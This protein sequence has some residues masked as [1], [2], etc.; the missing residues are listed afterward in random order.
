M[1]ILTKTFDGPSTDVQSGLVWGEIQPMGQMPSRLPVATSVL[2]QAFASADLQG[3]RL[4]RSPGTAL[5]SRDTEVAHLAAT[6]QDPL[7]GFSANEGIVAGIGIG[8]YSTDQDIQSG[9]L[10][11]GQNPFET[12]TWTFLTRFTPTTESHYL[13]RIMQVQLAGKWI[14]QGI[15]PPTRACRSRAYAVWEHLYKQFGLLPLRVAAS[16]DEGISLIYEHSNGKALAVEVYND[17]EVA[18]LV[19]RGKE[20]L[21]S[22]TI[23]DLNFRPVF[24]VLNV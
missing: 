12:A 10:A 5:Y 6:S 9:L 2:S 11:A 18:A 14:T 1:T 24:L 22:E 16:A 4:V 19:N 23:D 7:V 15:R 20:I 17:L 13:R 21:Y 3:I 8:S